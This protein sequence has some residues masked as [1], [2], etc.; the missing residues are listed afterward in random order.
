MTVNEHLNKFAWWKLKYV[1]LS[2]IDDTV[3]NCVE[4]SEISISTKL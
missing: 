1:E 3:Y 4:Q 2:K